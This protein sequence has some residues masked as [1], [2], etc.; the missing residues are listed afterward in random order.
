MINTLKY[1]WAILWLFIW[2]GCV[3]ATEEDKTIVVKDWKDA[4]VQRVYT[5][6]DEL[7]TDSLIDLLDDENATVRYWASR[8]FASLKSKKAVEPL[9]PLLQ[10]TVPEI[11]YMSAYALGQIGSADATDALVEAFDQ[12]SASNP[13]NYYILQAVG[14]VAPPK[15]LPLIS[16]V[17]TY[18]KQDTHLLAG[19]TNGIYEYMLRGHT[20][21]MGTARMIDIVGDVEY[22][23]RV[24]LYAA[25]Y[26]LRANDLGLDTLSVDTLLSSTFASESDPRI[27]MALAMALGKTKSE[28]ALQSLQNQYNIEEEYRVKCN[29]IR[30][31]SNFDYRD[32]KALVMQALRNE[33]LHIAQTAAQYV[34]EY[35]S[36]REA[37]DYRRMARDTSIHPRVQ[38]ALLAAA[39]ARMPNFFTDYKAR[40]AYNLQQRYEATSDPY[41]KAAALEAMGYY[42]RSYDYVGELEVSDQHPAVRTARIQALKTMLE[43]ESYDVSL[44]YRAERVTRTI[45]G[46][47]LEAIQSGDVGQQA[48]AAMALRTPARD[49]RTLFADSLRI[50]EKSMDELSQPEAIETYNEIKRTVA[51]FKGESFARTLPKYNHPINWETVNQINNNTRVNLVTNK[52]TIGLRLFPDAAPATVANFVQLA[53][54]G[55]FNGKDFHRV[56]ANFVVQGGGTRGDGYGSVPHTIRTEISPFLQYEVQGMVGMASAGSHTESSQF[57]ITHSP[58]LHLNGDYTIFAEVIQGMEVVH[59]IQ[60][61]DRI[62]TVQI[63]LQSP[64][65]Q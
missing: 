26:L 24:R 34:K 32:S 45:G 60:V 30:A 39:N 37:N 52:G 55:F 42:V 16:S 36:P 9:L 12:R 59:D 50:L 48:L 18:E 6:Q 20:H 31:L 63:D 47:L 28:L 41:L 3:P 65:Y 19:L 15:Y 53:Q 61:G 46:Y 22:L 56:V 25:N 27:R 10:D 49:Y 4:E 40:I 64:T 62:E 5:L 23:D 51:D 13:L 58:A 35:G 38:I 17:T 57:F 33:N 29:I 11:R 54:D 7:K 44:G 8:A 21:P 2:Q 43:D 14:K 1:V